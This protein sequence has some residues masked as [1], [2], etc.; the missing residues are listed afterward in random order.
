MKDDPAQ[1]EALTGTTVYTTDRGP[2]VTLLYVSSAK[3]DA[4]KP[5][6]TSV[7]PAEIVNPVYVNAVKL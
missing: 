1:P 3:A 7:D 6:A 4:V 5:F 2:L